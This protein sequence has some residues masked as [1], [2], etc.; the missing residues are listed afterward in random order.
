MSGEEEEAAIHQLSVMNQH[1]SEHFQGPSSF[2]S[3][4]VHIN[5]FIP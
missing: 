3:F 4:I 2:I 5:N 1:E